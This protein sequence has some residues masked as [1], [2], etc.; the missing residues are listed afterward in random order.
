MPILMD[1]TEWEVTLADA[2]RSDRVWMQQVDGKSGGCLIPLP[3]DG[4]FRVIF[5]EIP[6][7]GEREQNPKDNVR[8]RIRDFIGYGAK[9]HKLRTTEEWMEELR[10]GEEK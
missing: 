7:A 2:R 10:E 8:P 5:V 9:F 1:K 6:S 3:A 4:A